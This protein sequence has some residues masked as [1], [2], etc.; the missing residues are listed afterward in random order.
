M[1]QTH[2]DTD[3]AYADGTMFVDVLGDGPKVRILEVLLSESNNDMN[4]T[5]ICKL[6][7]IST[8][9]FYNY[10]DDLRRWGLV[11]KTRMAGNSPMYQINKDSEAA[12]SLAKFSWELIDFFG[13]KE[14]AGELTEDNQPTHPD[15]DE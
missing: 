7:G 1:S 9:S 4:P 6:A 14:Q 15:I 3:D 5:R 13:E 11:K 8:S 2:T 12:Q 10:I